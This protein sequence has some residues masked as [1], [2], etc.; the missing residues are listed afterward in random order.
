MTTPAYELALASTFRESLG[1]LDPKQVKAVL[2]TIDKLQAGLSS[3]HIHALHGLP[4]VSFVVNRDALRVICSRDGNTLMLVWVDAHDEAYQW[5]ER[6]RSVKVGKVIRLLTVQAGNDEGRSSSTTPTTAATTTVMTTATPTVAGPLVDVRDKTF[7]HV[8][9]GPRLAAQLRAVPDDDTLLELAERLEPALA[10][11]L[12]SLAADPD[13]VQGIVARYARAKDGETVTFKEAMQATVNAERVWL[14]PPEQAALEAALSADAASWRVF[15][16]ASQKRLVSMSTSGPFLVM[17]G[18]GTGKTVVALHR[19]RHLLSLPTINASPAWPVVLTTFSRVLAHQ[20]HIGLVDL[21]RDDPSR[22]QSV[23]TLTLTAAARAVLTLA[24]QPSSLLLD[25]DLDAAWAEALRLDGAGRGRAFYVVERDEVVLARGITTVDAYLKAPRGGRGGRL[26]RSAKL[27]V[28]AVLSSYEAALA[29]R[30]GDDAGGLARR[31]TQLLNN[32]V[33]SSP[34]A[35]VV[36][37]EVQDA[38][39]WELRLLAALAT[40]AGKKEPGPDRLFMVG[41]GHQRLTKKPTSLRSCGI[42]VRGRSA[43]LRLNYRTT[44]GICAQAIELIAGLPMDVIDHDAA[45][46]AAVDANADPVADHGYRSVRAGPRPIV[47]QFSS[48]DDEAAFVADVIRGAVASKAVPVLL[49]ARTTS[50]VQAMRERLRDRGL[51]VPILGEL[52]SLPTGVD[53]VLCTLHRSKG[54]EAPTVVL[55]GQQEVPQRYRAGLD[56]DREQW[57]RQER[58]LQYVGMTRAR[59]HC[60]VTRVEP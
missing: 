3:V 39:A 50:M 35:A 29:H 43:R 33:V 23:Q 30:G 38:S 57:D 34:F 27:Q 5:A 24:A 53:A 19:V 48:S 21:C 40:T 55:C 58:L 2:E 45:I 22:V 36:C 44:Q 15:L 8:E 52:D 31:A 12:L 16:H 54:L 1:A 14:V 60:V 7:R 56:V 32:G 18:P 26:E 41:D 47:R 49:L 20:L 28:W 46:D 10:E 17:G 25:E 9:V 59:D 37:D 13:D 6:H 42:E 11:A 4:W 51:T